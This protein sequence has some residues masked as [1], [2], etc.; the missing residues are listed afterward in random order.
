MDAQELQ[1]LVVLARTRDQQAF[2]KLVTHYYRLAYS[3]AY[4]TV[5]DWSAAQD[6]AQE[7]FLVAWTH[8]DNL[9]HAGAFPM[10]I[11]KIARNLSLNWIRSAN[12]RRKLTERHEQI[13]RA[14]V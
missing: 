3:L 4:S 8:L 13:G 6:I 10:W 11:R 12:Y 2:G 14:H 7:T 1:K 5:G 9:R